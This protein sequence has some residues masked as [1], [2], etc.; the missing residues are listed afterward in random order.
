VDNKWKNNTASNKNILLHFHYLSRNFTLIVYVL[1]HIF[2]FFL[3][4]TKENT[5]DELFSQRL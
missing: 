1:L 5:D 3:Q 4:R 2:F